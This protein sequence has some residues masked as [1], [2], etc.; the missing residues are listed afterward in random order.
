MINLS[1]KMSGQ[2]ERMINSQV[3]HIMFNIDL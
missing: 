3:G 1:H 2:E